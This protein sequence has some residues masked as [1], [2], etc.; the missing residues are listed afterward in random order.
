M[1]EKRVSI[2]FLSSRSFLIVELRPLAGL[3]QRRTRRRVRKDIIGPSASRTVIWSDNRKQSRKRKRNEEA[4]SDNDDSDRT[5]RPKKHMG[6]LA[7]GISLMDNFT[8]KN[9]VRGRL[10]VRGCSARVRPI[11]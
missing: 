1:S 8:A 2:P 3:V 6:K 10:T 4:A 11:G 9:V 7:L 5:R